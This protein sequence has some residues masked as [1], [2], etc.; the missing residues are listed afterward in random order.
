[1]M[2]NGKG[3]K[4]ALIRLTPLPPADASK[5]TDSMK[6]YLKKTHRS[7]EFQPPIE[8]ENR[9]NTERLEKGG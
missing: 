9:G 5:G 1:M 2:A 8:A 7:G 4:N 6:T 3:K